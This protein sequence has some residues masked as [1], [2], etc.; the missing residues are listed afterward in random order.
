MEEPEENF[1]LNG[2]PKAFRLRIAAEVK[3]HPKRVQAAVAELRAEVKKSRNN[4]RRPG[5]TAELL[6]ALKQVLPPAVYS[7]N[8]SRT[9]KTP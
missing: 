3:R 8:F 5:E 2:S 6:A 9:T 4:K 7:A 1:S